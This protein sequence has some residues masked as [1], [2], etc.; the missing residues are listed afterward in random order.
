MPVKN[1]FRIAVLLACTTPA[2]GQSPIEP[3]PPPMLPGSV[4]PSNPVMIRPAT[5]PVPPV[6]TGL[7]PLTPM[8]NPTF[9]PFPPV[10]IKSPSPSS[11]SGSVAVIPVSG[12]PSLSVK[13]TLPESIAPGQ[14]VLA[15][16]SVTNTGGKLAE[17]VVLL[18][19]W[20]EGFEISETSVVS[21]SSNGKRAWGMGAIAAGETRTLKVKLTPIATARPTEFRSGFDATFS[22]SASDTRSVKV[23]KP[24]LN[25]KIAAP[26]TT[27][28]GQPVTVTI[29]LKNP[30][31]SPV[32]KV[33]VQAILPEGLQHPKAQDLVSD[34]PALAAGAGESVPLE[35]TATKLGE[36][37]GKIRIEAEGCEP[38]DHEFRIVV[39]EA[40]LAVSI[41]GPKTLYQNWPATYEAVIE[42]QG[43]Y[44]LK[45]ASLEVKL[46]AGMSDLRASDKPGHNVGRNLMVWTFDTLQP[47]E[48]KTVIWFGFAK[49]P[50]DLLTTGTIS[51]GGAPLRRAEWLTKNL[52][53]EGK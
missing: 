37:K 23:T 53:S 43:S 6:E 46:P 35:L 34:L 51:V 18:G 32:G 22:T 14:A 39:T 19:W 10:T 42:N 1:F 28:L 24:E 25:L 20:S 31:A 21:Y 7:V 2:F 12:Q 40:K 52:G 27:I 26:D 48:K 47:G 44:P 33:T 29:H 38:I 49:Q 8:A 36:C 15:E 30:G 16:V 50:D 9:S 5:A 17:N 13:Q 11:T 3:L 45:A 41:S 4:A